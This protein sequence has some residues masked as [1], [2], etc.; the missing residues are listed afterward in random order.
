MG[1]LAAT[2]LTG[3]PDAFKNAL[4]DLRSHRFPRQATRD[5]VIVAIDSRSIE[6]IGVWPWPRQL[7]AELI[8]KLESAKASD[9]VFDVDFS[10]PSNPASDRAF[11]EALKKAGGS[12]VLPSFKQPGAV[13]GNPNA[14]HINRPLKQFSDQSW[15]AFVNVAIEPETE[16]VAMPM[17]VPA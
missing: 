8:G 4:T 2:L 6:A 17:A 12:V 14:L 10:A 1:A 5:I 9:I 3:M 7:H 15:P 16:A 13:S 11:V